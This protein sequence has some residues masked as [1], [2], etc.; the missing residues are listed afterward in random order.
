MH[1]AGD[2]LTAAAGRTNQCVRSRRPFSGLCVTESVFYDG[3]LTWEV[4]TM[5]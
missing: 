1:K 2:G 4:M 5:S 3:A